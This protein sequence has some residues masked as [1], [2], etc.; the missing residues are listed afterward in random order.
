MLAEESEM[1]TWVCPDCGVK[2]EEF[3]LEGEQLPPD[4]LDCDFCG[5]ESGPIDW[6]KDS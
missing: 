3:I 5:H 1:C 6:E 4:E 2:N